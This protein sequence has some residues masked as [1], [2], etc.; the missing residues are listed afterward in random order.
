MKPGILFANY[1]REVL[2]YFGLPCSPAAVQLLVMIAAHESDNFLYLKQL[3][4]GPA[5][6]LLQ[7]EPVGLKE[8]IR[9]A[10]LR[11]EKFELLPVLTDVRLDQLIFDTELAILCARVFFMAKP[12]PLPPENDIEALAK[13]A[14][15][16]WNTRSGKAKWED[17]YHAFKEHCQ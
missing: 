11:P 16:H 7:M 17:Y 15:E 4:K 12:E 8:V 9:Y 5:R 13:Y 6:G 2:S 3:K 1:V 10:T 14:K